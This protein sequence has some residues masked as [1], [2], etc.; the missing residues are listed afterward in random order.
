MHPE[1]VCDIEVEVTQATWAGCWSDDKIGADAKAGVYHGCMTYTHTIGS[2]PRWM[3]FSHSILEN[4][5][6]AG[7]LTTLDE[8]GTPKVNTSSDLSGLKAAIPPHPPA[9][10]CALAHPDLMRLS[11]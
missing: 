4:N 7:L 11:L 10:R 3:E 8:T 9:R 6:P 2:R 1:Q 5:K